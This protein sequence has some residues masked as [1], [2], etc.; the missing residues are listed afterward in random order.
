MN[1]GI[2]T[3]AILLSIL[4]A[5]PTNLGVIGPGRGIELVHCHPGDSSTIRVNDSANQNFTT[6]NSIL[7]LTNYLSML[8]VGT[9][10]LHIQS[11]CRGMTGEVSVVTFELVRIPP[12]IVR[13]W[14]PRTTNSIPIP[15]P[16]LPGGL[17]LPL[18]G[19]YHDTYPEYRKRLLEGKRRSQ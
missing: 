11:I 15:M 10:T 18:P 17:I 13:R 7:T 9:N 1:S 6:T 8:H 14:T 5:D 2:L 4:G 19:G 12:P 3:I 16:P